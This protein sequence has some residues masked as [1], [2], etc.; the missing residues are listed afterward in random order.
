MRVC[1]YVAMIYLLHNCWPLPQLM[2]TSFFFENVTLLLLLLA[3]VYAVVVVGG[4]VVGLMRDGND[5]HRLSR[6]GMR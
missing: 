2:I 3:S 4:F 1:T 5:R 6:A